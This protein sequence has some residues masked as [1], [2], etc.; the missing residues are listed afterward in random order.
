MVMEYGMSD[1]LGMIKYGDAEETKHLGY[2][3]GGGKDYS[4]RTAEIIDREIKD[5]VDDAYSY[6]K[7]VLKD[8]S[9]YVEKLVTILL[10]KVV[11]GKEEFEG[12]FQE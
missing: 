2:A 11:V 7:K 3:Y 1:K 12:I 10:E 8:Q 5:L 4:E 9:Q 6:A